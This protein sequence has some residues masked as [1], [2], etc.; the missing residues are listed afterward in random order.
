MLIYVVYNFLFTEAMVVQLSWKGI[1]RELPKHTDNSKLS[2][3]TN[4]AER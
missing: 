4:L 3:A 1:D 2:H